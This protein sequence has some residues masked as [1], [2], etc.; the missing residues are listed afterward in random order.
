MMKLKVNN[1]H[2]SASR[3]ILSVSNKG[4]EVETA[5][6]LWTLDEFRNPGEV[7]PEELRVPPV[8]SVS[9]SDKFS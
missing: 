9:G 5:I 4:K 3:Q 1:C 2:C 7:M 8:C 6:P